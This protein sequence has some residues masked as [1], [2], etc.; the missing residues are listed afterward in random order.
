MFKLSKN[1]QLKS[2]SYTG[3]FPVQTI[4]NSLRFSLSLSKKTIKKISAYILLSSFILGSFYFWESGYP[5]ICHILAF[6]AVALY[7]LF[8]GGKNAGTAI[9]YGFIFI[10]Y[11]FMISLIYFI[12]YKDVIT[13]ISF[14][15]YLFNFLIFYLI[16]LLIK[17]FKGWILSKIFLIHLL[18][19]IINSILLIY[20]GA[21]F[22][23]VQRITA[24]FN[25]PNQMANYILW[26]IIII[27]IAGSYLYGSLI[28]EGISI[29]LGI[30]CIGYS[31]SRSGFI[32]LV[33]IMT[34]YII[35][36]M[37]DS[38]GKSKKKQGKV[39]FERK[40]TLQ[41]LIIVVIL[42]FSFIYFNISDK[43]NDMKV[44]ERYNYL[45]SRFGESGSDDT[46]EGRGYDRL[47]KYPQYIITGAGEGATYRYAKKCYFL[48]EIHS[49]WAGLIFNYG[50]IGLFLFGLFLFSIF[51]SVHNKF[52]FGMALGPF[53]YGFFTYN[54]R[55]WY[56]WIGLAIIYSFSFLEQKEKS[57]Y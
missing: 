20:S 31:A 14:L 26:S 10:T 2:I 52:I 55:N 18:L 3:P 53:A 43:S 1:R 33:V 30:I 17:E 15:Y 51:K 56:F 41:T 42:S 24:N 57:I 49:T 21:R 40:K 32:G 13:I 12:L 44:K 45:L 34:V 37:Y 4:G 35:Q 46:L 6:L 48:G 28:Y 7:F 19:L 36:L 27:S 47:W 16:V 9:N 38:F 23:S 22:Q 29:L 50:I 25:D 54:L 5:Q 39:L 11:C 8:I